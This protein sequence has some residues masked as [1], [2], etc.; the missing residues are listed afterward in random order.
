[1]QFKR[2]KRKV[3]KVFIHCSAYAHQDLKG[4]KLKE[5][6]NKWHIERGFNGIGYH[7]VIDFEGTYLNGRDMERIPAAQKGYN[8]GSLAFCLDGLYKSQFNK[9]Q[10]ITLL[11]LI[12]QIDKS[13]KDSNIT[14]HGHCE[15]ANKT[16]PVFKYKTVLGLQENGKRMTGLSSLDVGLTQTHLNYYKVGSRTL[17]KTCYG[18]D[19][20]ELQSILKIKEDGAFGIDTS[21]AVI[22]FQKQHNLKPDGVVGPKTWKILLKLKA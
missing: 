9:S 21:I 20:E 4:N 10:F 14:Y 13:Y 3:N 6:I 8:T 5:A 15:V 7:G 19:V 2:P 22:N 12:N 17:I 11:Y 18:F 1:M 16:C